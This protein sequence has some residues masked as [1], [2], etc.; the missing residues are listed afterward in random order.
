[1]FRDRLR[2]SRPR[3]RRSKKINQL[4]YQKYRF[5]CNTWLRSRRVNAMPRRL[6][7]EPQR[8][9]WSRLSQ[10]MTRDTTPPLSEGVAVFC[11][12]ACRGEQTALDASL[13]GISQGCLT[14]CLLQAFEQRGFNCSYTDWVQAASSWA[15]RLRDEVLPSMDQFFQLYYGKNAAPDECVVLHPRTAHVAKDRS[16]RRRGTRHHPR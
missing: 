9:L 6:P 2:V 12:T 8:P 5:S 7:C 13:D 4:E 1:M 16:R 3:V 14:Y 10:L 11:I 15:L